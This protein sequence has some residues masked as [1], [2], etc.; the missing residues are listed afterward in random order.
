MAT[1][2]KPPLRLPN[3]SINS[4]TTTPTPTMNNSTT[5]TPD[6]SHHSDQNVNAPITAPNKNPDVPPMPLPIDAPLPTM[7]PPLPRPEWSGVMQV[8]NA[9][10]SSLSGVVS[11][12][13]F[14]SSI[15]DQISKSFAFIGPV[16]SLQLVPMS[17]V[18]AL[19]TTANFVC[20]KPLTDESAFSLMHIHDLMSR[21]LL[22]ASAR[23]GDRILILLR[24][25]NNLVLTTV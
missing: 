22:C 16:L 15:Q 7:R 14:E 12:I 8:I 11:L 3:S 2:I 9:D 13:S 18:P 21:H 1:S 25:G 5:A 4:T 17:L 10:G 20:V 24:F 19:P 6:S 23:E